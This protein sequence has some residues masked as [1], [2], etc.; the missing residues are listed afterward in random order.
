MQAKTQGIENQSSKYSVFLS[1]FVHSL[2]G[3]HILSYQESK[4]LA[5]ST[6]CNVLDLSRP[7]APLLTLLPPLPKNPRLPLQR[8][9]LLLQVLHNKLP[10]LLLL[11]AFFPWPLRPSTCLIR[12]LPLPPH[13]LHEPFLDPRAVL[14][15]FLLNPHWQIVPRWTVVAGGVIERVLFTCGAKSQVRGE[16]REGW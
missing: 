11:P 3:Y 15:F 8:I 1:S 5:M 16:A 12:P 10:Q 6:K 9:N 13:H 7:I 14:V 4:R 2:L